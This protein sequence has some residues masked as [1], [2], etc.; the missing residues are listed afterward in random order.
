MSRNNILAS[1]IN[2]CSLKLEKVGIHCTFITEAKRRPYDYETRD[3]RPAIMSCGT[4]LNI[5][6][7]VLFYLILILIQPAKSVHLLTI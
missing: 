5:S 3:E 2:M 7:L 1:C 6:T 4:H